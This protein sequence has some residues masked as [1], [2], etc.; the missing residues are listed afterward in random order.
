MEKSADGVDNPVE[1][2]VQKPGGFPQVLHKMWRRGGVAIRSCLPYTGY[3]H[4]TGINSLCAKA[5]NKKNDRACPLYGAGSSFNH[6]QEPHDPRAKD[7]LINI[8]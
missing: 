6:V 7:N 8:N 2:Y 1:N 5:L 3:I 4:R